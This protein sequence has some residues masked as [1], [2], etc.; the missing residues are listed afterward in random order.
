MSK[1]KRFH[2]KWASRVFD[3]EKMIN[4]LSKPAYKELIKVIDSGVKLTKELADQVAHAMKEWALDNGATHFTHWFQPMRGVTAEK[5]DS[6]LSLDNG[7]AIERF[8]GFQL[9]Q[10]EPDASSFPSGGMRSTFEARG[11]TGWDPTSPAFL[12]IGDK[13]ATLVI[14]SV[15]FSY[16][17]EVLDLKR[18]L[19]RSLAAV[20][21]LA[22]KVL[23]AFGNRTARNVKVTVGAEQEF[24][25]IRKD[26]L[27]NRLDLLLCGRTLQGA[28]SPKGQQFEDHYFGHIKP[29]V[30]S[31]MEEVDTCLNERGIVYK[32]R[33]NE[34]APNQFEFAPNFVDANL[35]VD[36]NL[37]L[38]EIM[39]HVADDHDF[40]L[41]FHE[42]PFAGVNGSGKHLNYSF[43]D[44]D[45][46]NLLEA[47]NSH[48]K[49]TQFLVFL[50]AILIGV[51]KYGALLRASVADA[52]N[53]HR[54]GANEA[55]PAVI[56]VFI[57]TYLREVLEHIEK[58]GLMDDVQTTSLDI[59]VRHLPSVKADVTDRNRTSPVAFTGNKFEFR[60]VGSSHNIS[61]S[62]TVLNLLTAYGL[63]VMLEKIERHQKRVSDIRTAAYGAIRE[64]MK[65]SKDILFEGNNYGDAWLKEAKKRNLPILP[66]TPAA[67]KVYLEPE[68][69]ALYEKYGVLTKAELC[70]RV[71]V[72]REAYGQIKLMELNTLNE[73]VKTRVVPA[74]VKQMESFAV[75]ASTL[76]AGKAKTLLNK[77]VKVLEDLFVTIEKD[78]EKSK[79][80]VKKAEAMEHDLEAMV[81]YLGIE[82]VAILEE[83][84]AAC[85]AAESEIEDGLWTIPKYSEMLHLT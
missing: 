75:T 63:E 31:F 18:P 50:S 82:G 17:G 83:L 84:R 69:M 41:L 70:A 27:Q 66:D 2:K 24:F 36:Q 3:Q 9:I 61:K 58:D 6:F 4:Y 67:L 47:G 43:Q 35:G 22:F 16:T 7:Q 21:K 81:D 77:K 33:H 79:K 64:A 34:V 44:S 28:P 78:I 46:N 12:M 76:S 38:M 73:M 30:M 5:H 26:F 55:P 52:G 57:G 85:D 71:D 37:Q 51:K 32:T 53:D 15:H 60:A 62:T 11:Y 42:K 29:K 45:G 25:L 1:G 23:K 48:K 19:L 14:P 54:L 49:N 65:E 8:S 74:L 72:R 39:R 80:I 59:K 13:K 56:S 20:E 68:M 10:S 40:A